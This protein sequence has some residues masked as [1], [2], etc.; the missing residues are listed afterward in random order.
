MGTP[1]ARITDQT[2][3]GGLITVGCPTVLIGK[4]PA[5]RVGDLHT[6]PLVTVL[7]PHVGGPIIMG[8]WTVLVSFVPQARIGDMVVCVGPPDTVLKGEPTVL[9]GSAGGGGGLGSILMGL[10]AGLGNLLGG[11]PKAVVDASGNVVT[12][13][14]S[15]ITIQ[16]SPEYQA[17]VVAD[18]NRFLS[19]PAGV[20]WAAAYAATGRNITIRP[21]AAGEQQDNGGCTRVSPNDALIHVAADG[22]ETPGAGSDSIIDYNPSYTSHYTGEDGQTYDSPPH[23]TLGHEMIHGLHNGEGEN[24]RNLA[25]T[26]PNGD[27]QE[28]ARTIG[29]HGYEGEAI[30]ERQMSEDARGTGSARPDH[31]SVPGSTYQDENGVWHETATDAGGTTTDTVIPAPLGGAPNH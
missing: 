30:S 29:V 17:A 18:L 4:L 7:V 16:G 24:R 11:Y 19:T 2:A 21:I 26:Q 15:Q 10:A 14:N 20:D 25:D 27:N 28:E 31:D 23:E 9:V 6:C 8:A 12:Q 1:A 13:F 3:H 5:A 22:T